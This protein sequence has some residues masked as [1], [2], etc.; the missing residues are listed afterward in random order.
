LQGRGVG[1][2]LPTY[3]REN[4]HGCRSGRAHATEPLLG[5]GIVA[6][7]NEEACQVPDT[8]ERVRWEA[9]IGGAG[10][11][12]APQERTG[13]DQG[14]LLGA[15][16]AGVQTG[17][18]AP[19]GWRTE[20]GAAPWLAE[21]GLV[22]GQSKAYSA[23]TRANAEAADG[24]VLFGDHLSTGSA[25]TERCCN[26]LGKPILRIPIGGEEADVE[27]AARRLADSPFDSAM[28]SLS[29]AVRI[30]SHGS[31]VFCFATDGYLIRQRCCTSRLNS[32]PVHPM[33]TTVGSS[34]RGRPR[35]WPSCRRDRR[36]RRCR[37]I[38]P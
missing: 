18:M 27:D 6:K 19:R 31:T 22:E 4:L 17:G 33:S 36:S 35:N 15:R 14:G 29:S 25:L 9:A 3:G 1:I 5:R 13:A 30:S 34:R 24:T 32:P 21:F 26:E 7:E 2:P 23:R 10:F 11:P 37:A 12:A 28:R 16:D 8:A 38:A 20:E